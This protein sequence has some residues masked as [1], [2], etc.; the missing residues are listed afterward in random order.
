[1]NVRVDPVAPGL[2]VRPGAPWERSTIALLG[3]LVIWRVAYAVM[4][5]L[6]LAPDEAYYWDWS[7]RL[8]WGYV[9]K[10]PLVAWIIAAA[11]QV[12]GVSEAAIRLPAALLG[13]GT[14]FAA[15]GLAR[16]LYDDRVART[17]LVLLA[18]MPGTA[19]G[20]ALMTIDAPF[21]CAWALASW[22]LWLAFR[23]D[24]TAWWRVALAVAATG[25]GLL[26]KQTMIAIVPIAFAWIAVSRGLRG[27]RRPAP[28]LWL[29]SSVAC[30]APVVWWNATHGWPLLAHT[31]GHFT[32][33]AVPLSQRVFWSVE[34]WVTQFGLMTPLIAALVI[35]VLVMA[36]REWRRQPDRRLTFAL[37]FSA[38]PLLGVEALSLLQRVQP[39]WPAPFYLTAVI[40]LAAWV[41]GRIGASRMSRWRAWYPWAMTSG[42][43]LTAMT[44]VVPFAIARTPLAGGRFD[45]TVRVRGWRE[46]G[47]QLAVTAGADAPTV[48]IAATDRGPV[49]LLAFYLP[50]R[51]RVYA[52]NPSGVVVT[53]HDLWGGLDAHLGEDALI[54]TRDIDVVSADLRA[55]FDEV[56][57]LGRVETSLG[58]SRRTALRV[59]HGRT[60]H[61]PIPGRA[62]R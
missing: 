14:L 34:F 12:A 24:R 39:N 23:D 61:T 30:L 53:Q 45:P 51:P 3:L 43:V 9:S 56:R 36:A 19:A 20:A 55:S 16:S 58:R 42:L 13:G 31:G 54:V 26:A 47:E 46:L 5:P 52:W 2:P 7:R 17:T 60:L 35:G 49:S 15:A 50:G 41:N 6:D 22:A 8:D 1:V 38:V 33:R 32:W 21:L 25:A 57:P 29:T 18:A 44:H 48:V 28:W 27:W 62:A 40:L 37:M 11:T 10:P 59:W 4:L